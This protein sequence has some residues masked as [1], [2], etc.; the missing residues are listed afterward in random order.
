MWDVVDF[1]F[2]KMHTIHNHTNGKIK[3]FH[4]S[5]KGHKIFSEILYKKLYIKPE[6]L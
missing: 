6:L 2:S 3:D 5:F 4:F 1:A